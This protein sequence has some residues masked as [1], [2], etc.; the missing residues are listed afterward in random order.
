MKIL[1]YLFLLLLLLSVGGSVF[2]ATQKSN[3]TTVKSIVIKTPKTSVYNY[4][5]DNKNFK[6]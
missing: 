1:K 6:D 4:L 2:I 3:F 5:N